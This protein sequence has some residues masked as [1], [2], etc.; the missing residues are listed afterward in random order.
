MKVVS[1]DRH[2]KP[3]ILEPYQVPTSCHLRLVSCHGVVGLVCTKIACTAPRTGLGHRRCHLQSLQC[4]C[5]R[6]TETLSSTSQ[7]NSPAPRASDPHH[8]SYLARKPCSWWCKHQAPETVFCSGNA[9]GQ[10]PPGR[11]PAQKV[12]RALKTAFSAPV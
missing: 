9:Q 12:N 11:P 2:N 8:G 10:T 3:E 6:V 4:M 5:F 1:S 7:A